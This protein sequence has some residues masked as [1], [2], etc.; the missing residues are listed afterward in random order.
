MPK[1]GAPKSGAHLGAVRN[2]IQWEAYNGDAVTWGSH[3]VLNIKQNV[4]PKLLEDLAQDI[5]NAIYDDPGTLDRL[6]E[7][8]E[9]QWK[10]RGSPAF[11]LRVP[12]QLYVQLESHGQMG[13]YLKF[14]DALMALFRSW[15]KDR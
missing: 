6:L 2:W 9:E 8:M 14:S 12:E 1:H 7:K 15:T 5:A 11:M 4:T 10:E 13:E 3:E